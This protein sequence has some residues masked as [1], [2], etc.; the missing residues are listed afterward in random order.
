MEMI[1]IQVGDARVHIPKIINGLTRER[2][3]VRKAYARMKPDIVAMQISDKELEGLRSVI[4]GEEFDYF[5]SNYEEIYARKLADFGKVKVPPPCYETAMK[6]CLEDDTPAVAIDMDDL[7]YADIF[8][9]N[10]STR[11]LLRHSLRVKKL[12]KKK[13][14]AQTAEEF[15]L[16]WDNE[17]NKLRGFRNLE[18]AREEY[19]A[20]ELIRLARGHERILCIMEMQRAEGVCDKLVEI[21]EK[22][23]D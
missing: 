17:I 2:G 4:E 18:N 10:V 20:R 12:R 9:E 16:E 11:D 13:F 3:K 7:Y 5:M 15:V 23:E 22:E 6:L 8:C 1:K 21:G 19:M 14:R